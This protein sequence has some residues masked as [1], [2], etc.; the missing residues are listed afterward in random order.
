MKINRSHFFT[1]YRTS[2]GKLSQKEVD[3]LNFLLDKLE[4][5]T[6]SLEQSAYI[7]ATVSHETGREFQPIKEKRGRV[8]TKIR[9]IQDKYWDTDAWGRG[10]VQITW[11]A[12]YAKFGMVNKED[13]DKALEPEK[14][15]EILSVGMRKGVFTGKK[16]SDYI[17]AGNV[18]YVQ[19]R[20][21][22]NGLDRANDIA[23]IA[24]KFEDILR[25]SLVT[26]SV[27]E[28]Q[29]VEEPAASPQVEP[30]IKSQEPEPPAAQPIE[31][32]KEEKVTVQ[33]VVQSLGSKLLAGGALIGSIGS[34]LLGAFLGVIRNPYAFAIM[35]V[36][37]AGLAVYAWNKSKDRQLRLQLDLNAKAASR[38]LNTVVMQAP[39]PPAET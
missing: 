36:G 17:T 6:F 25:A 30:E 8:G 11:P 20:R 34:A 33:K 14:A 10:F 37:G 21:I 31:E 1:R 5:D 35:I 4:K 13:Y 7:L 28:D 16:L 27:T 26:D 38:D 24:D 12:N 29:K 39:P 3:G 2:F 22:V 19:A 18:D 9:K 32:T 15:Y 23:D